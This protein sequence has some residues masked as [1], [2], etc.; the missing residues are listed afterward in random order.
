MSIV[1]IARPNLTTLS[2]HS[3]F[4]SRKDC[5]GLLRVSTSFLAR[6]EKQHADMEIGYSRYFPELGYKQKILRAHK[7]T[8]KVAFYEK[9][10]IDE[11]TLVLAR[12]EA[13]KLEMAKNKQNPNYSRS[14]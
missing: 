4:I 1:D 5:A 7:F 14:F 6:L 11:L 8:E 12:L 13:Y 3:R 2:E 9:E 10:Q